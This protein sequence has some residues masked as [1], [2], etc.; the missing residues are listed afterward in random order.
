MKPGK[1]DLPTL[2]R[3]CSYPGFTLVWLFSAGGAPID[4]TN[5]RPLAKSK[6]IDFHPV[7]YDPINGG[8]YIYLN[9]QE[10]TG[11]PLGVEQW[12][13]IWFNVV[14]G[15]VTPPLLSGTI[16]I[17]E[18]ILSSSNVVDVPITVL[19]SFDALKASRAFSRSRS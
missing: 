4:L 16:T 10:T 12:D 2:W 1:L 19:P 7:V 8:T 14:T 15:F 5:W 13:W 11:L 3:G 9:Y 6:S 18:P 17:K